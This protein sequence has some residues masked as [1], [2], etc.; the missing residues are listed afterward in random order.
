MEV[1]DKKKL[2]QLILEKFGIPKAAGLSHSQALERLRREF[3]G[4]GGCGA[5]GKRK[6]KKLKF[7]SK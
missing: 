5:K 7:V 6:R 1:F 3:R 4:S 2:F